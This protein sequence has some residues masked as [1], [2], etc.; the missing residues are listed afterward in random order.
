MHHHSLNPQPPQ[1]SLN[2]RHFLRATLA[3]ASVAAATPALVSCVSQSHSSASHWLADY[4]AVIPHFNLSYIVGRELA[5]LA[6][7]V[8]SARDA[9]L[10]IIEDNAPARPK[11]IIIGQTA[12]PAHATIAQRDQY[13]ISVRGGKIYLEGGHHY[14]VAAA[15]KKFTQLVDSGQSLAEGE[16]LTGSYAADSRDTSDYRLVLFDEFDGSAINEQLW[17]VLDGDEGKNAGFYGK[18]SYRR[19]K[20]CYVRDGK[21]HICGTRDDQAYYGGMLRTDRSFSYRYGYAEVSAIIPHGKAFW[22][23]FWTRG[24]AT[25]KYLAIEADIYECFGDSSRVAPNLHRWPTP[26]AKTTLGWQHTSLD[27]EFNKTKK[28]A[29]PDGKLFADDFHTYGLEW[30]EKHAAFTCDGQVYFAYQ[31]R[32]TPQDKHAFTET[33]PH[34]VLSLACAFALRQPPADTVFTETDEQCWVKTNKL[35]VEYL[36]LYQKPGQILKPAEA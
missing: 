29:C 6:A 12:R 36:H 17:H 3:G 25:N 26:Y 23:A 34:F 27:R 8:K 2:R 21:L 18:T 15:V 35:I 13:L 10:P 30:D 31:F 9:Q 28:H 32:D 22:T 5:P 24:P 33:M 16:R 7:A 14:S 20:N 4:V 1:P 19:A 11:E